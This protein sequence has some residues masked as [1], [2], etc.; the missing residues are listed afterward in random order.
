MCSAS[1]KLAA[2]AISEK[3]CFSFQ[4]AIIL[5][6][7]EIDW[8]DIDPS[9]PP[10]EKARKCTRFRT[11]LIMCMQACSP[12]AA[13]QDV[14]EEDAAPD[15]APGSR[16]EGP[17]HVKKPSQR[18]ASGPVQ[19]PSPSSPAVPEAGRKEVTRS[20]RRGADVASSVGS[21]RGGAGDD[22][23]PSRFRRLCMAAEE[24]KAE[25]GIKGRGENIHADSQSDKG[26]SRACRPSMP[27]CTTARKEEEGGAS[28][29][30]S[31]SSSSSWGIP[32][33][34]SCTSSR[35]AHGES[36]AEIAAAAAAAAAAVATP[37]TSKPQ[38]DERVGTAAPR[39]C[40]LPSM[41]SMPGCSTPSMPSMPGCSAP[42]LPTMPGCSA[43][44][45]PTMPGC[46]APSMP[47]APSC[48][49]SRKE[50]ADSTKTNSSGWM[51][52]VSCTGVRGNQ[53]A[54]APEAGAGGEELQTVWGGPEGEPAAV[55]DPVVGAANCADVEAKNPPSA[56]QRLSC[57]GA[58]GEGGGNGISED[59]G[60]WRESVTCAGAREKYAPS[61]CAGS[62]KVAS[63]PD[64]AGDPETAAAA[65]AMEAAPT[66]EGSKADKPSW[67]RPPFVKP[68]E[69]AT[70]PILQAAAAVDSAQA[71]G[72]AIS[73][74][75]SGEVPP[76]SSE[77]GGGGGLLKK[78]KAALTAPSCA[79]SRRPG[80]TTR[81]P[82]KEVIIQLAEGT[83]GR[84][85]NFPP[86]PK[87]FASKIQILTGI[88]FAV[89]YL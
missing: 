17:P 44:S 84:W 18:E 81:G 75:K 59:A 61:S 2:R 8:P 42:S 66:D 31:T 16:S 87:S 20:R 26:W 19:G 51:S 34:P 6:R 70:V 12:S 21:T 73:A 55:I 48:G 30:P 74:P 33:M 47:S 53:E 22:N 5:L 78:A 27:S 89:L 9:H 69:D 67:W 56:W 88:F 14:E 71:R 76:A 62:R 37:A 38:G 40:G 79:S 64:A 10:R 4:G 25:G 41:P 72:G 85:M 36:S 43:P 39:S 50:D 32:A 7:C 15:A 77:G 24:K 83:C 63:P 65:V 45:M 80:G 82:V 29:A 28:R 35:K 3:G 1:L 46:S 68:A 49:R 86:R 60:G 13:K 58:R 54:S 23:K 11:V 52:S 57:A